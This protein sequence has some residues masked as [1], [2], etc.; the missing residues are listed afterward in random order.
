[1]VD[2]KKN[3]SVTGKPGLEPLDNCK[4]AVITSEWNQE[5]TYSMREACIH[6]LSQYGCNDDDIIS[7]TVPGAF[8]LP[9]AAKMMLSNKKLGFEKIIV[10]KFNLKGISKSKQNIEIVPLGKVEELY[11]YLF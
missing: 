3:L 9:S 1:M 2:K 8:E 10:S 5:I 6:E 7:A 4:I 11:R